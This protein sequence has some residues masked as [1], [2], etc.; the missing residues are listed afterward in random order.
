M[1]HSALLRTSA[2]PG[3][4]AGRS[5]AGR[6]QMG[7]AGVVDVAV[8]AA[9]PPEARGLPPGAALHAR[10][11]DHRRQ[12]PPGR[13]NPAA[14]AAQRLSRRTPAPTSAPSAPSGASLDQAAVCAAPERKHMS[15]PAE[16]PPAPDAAQPPACCGCRAVRPRHAR[17]PHRRPGS[18][19]GAAARPLASRRGRDPEP[20]RPLRTPDRRRAQLRDPEIRPRRGRGGREPAPRPRRAATRRAERGRAAH[21][22]PRRLRERGAELPGAPGAERHP[23]PRRAGRALRSRTP[24][25]DGRAAGDR[26]RGPWHGAAG[27]DAGLDLERPLA[28]AGH[29]RGRRRHAPAAQRDEKETAA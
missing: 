14:V 5:A 19:G 13:L 7:Y 11:T 21:Q 25:G 26:R 12:V 23:P 20:A 22:A 29:G 8:A 27:L 18:R 15:D 17:G 16:T 10:R 6:L 1:V 4:A 28:Q 9:E 24:P 3:Y 2:T